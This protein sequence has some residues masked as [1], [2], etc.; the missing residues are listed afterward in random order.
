MSEERP[1]GIIDTIRS[2][3]WSSYILNK[4]A[5]LNL[6]TRLKCEKRYDACKKI[7]LHL[8]YSLNAP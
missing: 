7:N 8:I 5:T 6:I 1:I 4:G 3:K 2:L